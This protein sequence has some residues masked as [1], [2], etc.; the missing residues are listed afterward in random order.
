MEREEIKQE[1]KKKNR[2][3]IPIIIGGVLFLALVVAMF[4]L[5]QSVAKPKRELRKQLEEAELRAFRHFFK[6]RNIEKIIENSD[7][8]KELYVETI[9]KI[10]KE[11][12]DCESH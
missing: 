1:V 11:L 12:A 9:Y 8:T 4:I 6:I 10:K 7:R 2:G 5:Y 3:L